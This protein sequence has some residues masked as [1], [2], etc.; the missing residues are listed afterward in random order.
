MAASFAP[1]AL[2]AMLQ[3]ACIGARSSTRGAVYPGE[4][5][6]TVDETLFAD[7][8]S[9]LAANR[10]ERANGHDREPSLLAGLVYDADGERLTPTYALKRVRATATTCP[11]ISIALARASHDGHPI[12]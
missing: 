6:A 1:G 9:T 3:T 12:R 8:Q 4:H 2:Y 5:A 11:G 7:V 10:V